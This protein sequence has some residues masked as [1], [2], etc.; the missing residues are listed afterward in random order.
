MDGNHLPIGIR[1]AQ[2]KFLQGR[3]FRQ[4][5]KEYAGTDLNGSQINIIFVLWQEDDITISQL[6][7]RTNLAKT[8]LSSMLERLEKAGLLT[9][10]ENPENRREIRVCLTQEARSLESGCTK[11]YEKMSGINFSGFSPEEKRAFVNGLDR[12]YSNLSEYSSSHRL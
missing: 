6:S 5:L 8:T 9:R 11:A 12:L 10:R 4:L 1:I 2:V 7:Q 3:I